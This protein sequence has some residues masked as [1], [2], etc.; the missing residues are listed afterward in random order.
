[1]SCSTAAIPIILITDPS[2]ELARILETENGADE[3]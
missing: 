2:N 1:M 3:S